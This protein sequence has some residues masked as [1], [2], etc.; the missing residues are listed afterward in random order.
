[1][2]DE[3]GIA[4]IGHGWISRVH[5]H[6]LKILNDLDVL[7][8]RLRLITVA[9]RDE[10][11]SRAAASR[12]GFEES[13][14]DW[15]TV[16][17][18]AR[19]DVVANLTVE[20]AHPETSI[21]ALEG[22]KHVLCEKPLALS[23][24]A[25]QNMAEAAARAGRTAACGFMFRFAP[26]VARAR[27]LVADFGRPY[28]FRGWYN[29]DAGV[30]ADGDEGGAPPEEGGGIVVGLSHV[31]DLA[32]AMVG[33]ATSVTADTVRFP[34]DGVD[35]GST[36]SPPRHEEDA[37]A[38]VM[39]T[40]QGALATV[41]ASTHATGSVGRHT[42]EV[43][44]AEGAVRWTLD[45]INQ[46]DVF[47]RSDHEDGLPGFR[48]AMITDPQHPFMELWWPASCARLGFEHMFVHEWLLFLRA[49]LDGAPTGAGQASFDDGA[50]I[51]KLCDAI[52]LSAIDGRRVKLNELGDP[53]E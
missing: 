39:R 6:A 50:R 7:P 24:D 28:H 12:L 35:G 49:V 27:E 16:V 46:L 30:W 34:R 45:H 1:M 48:H 38:V 20:A 51:A 37:Y 17:D 22:G 32:R 9:G 26:A 13:T 19:I 2:N 31:L 40:D 53:I 52:M 33:D 23:G 15:R 10:H 47:T 4:F 44:A 21:G 25:A 5:A 8:V 11:R 41:G 36:F 43:E 14:A 42:V 3:I 18:D 29:L